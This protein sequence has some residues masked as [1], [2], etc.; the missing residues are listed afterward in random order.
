MDDN[1]QT[2]NIRWIL[3]IRNIFAFKIRDNQTD[4]N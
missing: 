4:E 1:K 3:K 2:E